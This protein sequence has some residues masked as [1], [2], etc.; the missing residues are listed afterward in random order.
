MWI[1]STLVNYVYKIYFRCL[2]DNPSDYTELQKYYDMRSGND[3]LASPSTALTD[4]CMLQLQMHD[5]SIN[6]NLL[7]LSY[8]N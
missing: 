2:L 5:S 7:G 3:Y 4:V 8:H 6:T 1:H